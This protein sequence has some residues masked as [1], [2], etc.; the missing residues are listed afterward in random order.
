MTTTTTQTG[1][2]SI[3]LPSHTLNALRAIAAQRQVSLSDVVRDMIR[4]A[5]EGRCP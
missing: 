1:K 5:M 3:V 4:R 2:V